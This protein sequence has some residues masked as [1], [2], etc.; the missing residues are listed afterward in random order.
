MAAL[1]VS[2]LSPKVSTAS[3]EAGRVAAD[4]GAHVVTQQLV[5]PRMLDLTVASPAMGRKVK[6][7][8]LLPRRWSRDTD[9]TWPVLYLLHGCCGGYEAWTANT[10]VEQIF[11][12]R[13]VLVVM[14]EAG[15]AGFYSDWWNHGSGGPPRWETFHLTEL[16]QILER[17][18]HAGTRRVIAGLS[19]GGFGA[20]SYT[21]RHPGMFLAAASYSGAVHTLYDPP[22]GSG[23]VRAVL[24]LGGHD[25]TALWGDPVLQRD[26]WAAH[27]PYDLAAPLGDIPLLSPAATV[28][29]APTTPTVPCRTPW[30][31]SSEK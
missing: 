27:N 28:S 11:N 26:I 23:V 8:L 3:A 29:P 6:A 16:R 31:R 21:A 12:N 19:M 22:R 9:R 2:P 10:D 1:T 14:S 25:P 15:F 13:D 30:R 20:M 24:A 5:A 7:R 18:Y 17:G 4:D